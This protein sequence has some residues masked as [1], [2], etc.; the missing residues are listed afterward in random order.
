MSFI[1]WFYDFF[2]NKLGMH[3]KLTSFNV[4]SLT[5]KIIENEKNSPSDRTVS[6]LRK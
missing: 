5:N 4:I 2:K 6:V 1:N 3:N